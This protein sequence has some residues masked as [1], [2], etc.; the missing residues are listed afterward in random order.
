LIGHVTRGNIFRDLGFGPVEAEYLRIRSDLAIAI[1]RE[2]RD[3]RLTQ[4]AAAKLLGVHPPRVSDLLRGKLE[5]F[6]L[7]TL[8]EMLTKLGVAVEVR[9]GKKVRRK[10]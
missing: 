3:R 9:V 1:E 4:V 7:E 2:I 5:L 8:I 6:S 10:R